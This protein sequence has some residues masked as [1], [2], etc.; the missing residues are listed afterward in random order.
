MSDKNHSYDVVV[1]GAGPGGYVAAIRAAQLGLKTALVDKSSHLGGT[2]LNVG[3]IPSKALLHSTEVY[4]DL[5]H[6]KEQY[7]IKADNIS[8]DVSALMKNKDSVVTKLTGG[9]N[10][11]IKA[12]KV[13]LFVGE[14]KFLN[15]QEIEVK[16]KDNVKLT[17]QNIII[18]TG[19]T[20]IELPFMKFDGKKIV[21]SDDAIAFTEVP[22]KLVVVGAGAIGL[23]LGSVWQRLGSDVT[24][25]ELLTKVA[26]TFDDDISK[27]AERFFKRQGMKFELGAK[28]TGYKEKGSEVVLTAEKDGKTLEFPADKILVAV[29]RKPFTEGLGLDNVGVKLDERKRVIVNKKYQTSIPMIYAIGDVTPGPMLAHKAEDEGVAVA[30]IIAGKAG[31]VNYTAIPN[32]IY[33]DPEIA[34]VG[35]SEQEAKAEGIPVSIGKF[36]FSANGRA[37]ASGYP[38]GLVKVIACAKNDTLL[39]VQIIGHNASELIAAAV[40]HMEYRGSAEDMA[41]TATAHPTLGEALKEAAM[42]VEKR[43]IHSM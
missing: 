35:I 2:C 21:S 7:G 8:A 15:V 42:A 34:S 1:I 4:H 32:V 9:I 6:K 25:V 26:P 13:A 29:G 41:R 27:H 28:V 16:G 5:L 43:S 20:S 30:E 10:Q 3:C 24:V 11:L 17:A 40:T 12:N 19:S 18:A 14:A 38:D 22:K 39:G 36:P 37:L 23:E 33:T 31:H